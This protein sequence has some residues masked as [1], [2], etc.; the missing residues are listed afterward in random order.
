MGSTLSVADTMTMFWLYLIEDENDRIPNSDS[1]DSSTD[2]NDNDVDDE[3]SA[4][5]A[6]DAMDTH[7]KTKKGPTKEDQKRRLR[8]YPYDIYDRCF[9]DLGGRCS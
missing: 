9:S 2:D 6:S 5:F 1:P 7:A 3:S 8:C 4:G